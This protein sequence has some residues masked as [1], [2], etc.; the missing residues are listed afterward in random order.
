MVWPETSEILEVWDSFTRIH[1]LLGGDSFAGRKIHPLLTTAGFRYIHV[2]PI[3]VYCD[4]GNQELRDRFI[5]GTLVPIIDEMKARMV[6]LGLISEK[7]CNSGI[8][9]LMAACESE[10]TFS[11]TFFRGI[12]VK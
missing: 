6:K 4:A 8:K 2:T 1:E 11:L 12:G 9:D 7:I 3:P 5:V 10:S